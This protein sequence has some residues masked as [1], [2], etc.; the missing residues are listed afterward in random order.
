MNALQG[1]KTEK[2]QLP[3]DV[4]LFIS[5]TMFFHSKPITDQGLDTLSTPYVL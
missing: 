2:A 3:L 4:V 1:V 5:N